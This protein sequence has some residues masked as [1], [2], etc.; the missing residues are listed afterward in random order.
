MPHGSVTHFLEWLELNSGDGHPQVSPSA[1][2]TVG[3]PGSQLHKSGIPV[4]GGDLR[5]PGSLGADSYLL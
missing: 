1:L 5:G 2:R 4:G 3:P